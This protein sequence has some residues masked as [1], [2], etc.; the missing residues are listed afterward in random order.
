LE[1]LDQFS[2]ALFYTLPAIAGM[3]ALIFMN[4]QYLKQSRELS[5]IEIKKQNLK[6][7]LQNKLQAYERL[8]LL[9]ERISPN[10]LL[11]RMYKTGNNVSNF[12]QELIA[13]IRAEFEHNLAQQL[14]VSE[15]SWKA[16]TD[17]KE[18]MVAIVNMASESLG[19]S[20]PGIALSK[21]II[22]VCIQQGAIPTQDAIQIIKLEARA[23]L[24]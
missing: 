18:A 5:L 4:K 23:I 11:P 8:I 19:E 2:T 24:H 9:M 6:L 1:T 13:T 14:Y 22:E 3:A 7:S 21:S 16:V 12:Q 15:R 10:S 20:S 17:A